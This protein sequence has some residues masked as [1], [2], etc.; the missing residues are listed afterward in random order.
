MVFTKFDMNSWSRRFSYDC[1]MNGTRCVQSITAKI[2]IT[3]VFKFIK[4]NGLRFYPVFTYIVSVAVNGRKE[5]KTALD[6][7]NNPGYYDIVHPSYNLFHKEDESV[8][9]AYTSYNENFEIFYSTMVADMEK[10]DKM[11][12]FEITQ[13]PINCFDVSC[14]PW[15]DYSSLDLHVFDKALYLAPVIVWGKISEINGHKLLPLTMQIH[16]ASAD[17]YHICSFFSN[18]ENIGKELAKTSL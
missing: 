7:G 12:G 5:F 1:F 6:S 3:E 8:S 14:L 15:L 17:G 10:Y 2:D 13:R 9:K 11:R 18:T 16:H 4:N